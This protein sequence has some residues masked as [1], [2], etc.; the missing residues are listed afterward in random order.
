MNER[1]S[2]LREFDRPADR[3]RQHRQVH[4]GP[5]LIVEGPHDH[6]LLKEHLEG[7][8]LFPVDGKVNVLTCLK[9]FKSW[10]I[11]GVFGITDRDFD[12]PDQIDI[13]IADRHLHY[14]GRDLEA[15]LIDLGVLAT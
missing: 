3:I 14:D 2:S 12:G 5:I 15:M 9:Q 1:A 6:L 13:E 8:S 11:Q 4:T 10:D 7:V